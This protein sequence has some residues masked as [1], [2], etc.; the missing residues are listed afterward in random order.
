M[1]AVGRSPARTRSASLL[2]RGMVR[3]LRLYKRCLSPLLPPRCRFYPSCSEYCR[4]AIERHGALK[5]AR[6]GL[7]R[8]CRCHPFSKGGV[9][10]VP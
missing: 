5:G 9:D 4:E 8:L 1:P 2:A 10:P 7:V 6:M 3:A